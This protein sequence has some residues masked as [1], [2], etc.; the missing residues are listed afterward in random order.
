MLARLRRRYR[1]GGL[2]MIGVRLLQPVNLPRTHWPRRVVLD[3]R[4]GQRSVTGRGSV[5]G[6]RWRVTQR[7]QRGQRR[8]NLRGVV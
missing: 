5:T 1:T 3:P 7:A 2:P 6:H 4:P 8:D